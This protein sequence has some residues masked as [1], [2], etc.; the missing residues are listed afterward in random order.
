MSDALS[1]DGKVAI[2]T[3]AAGGIGSE[4]AR[5]LGERGANVVLG[6]LPGTKLADAAATVQGGK[7]ATF[8]VDISSE[9]NVEAL[10]AFTIETFGRLD[11]VD[12]NAARQGLPGDTNIMSMTVEVWDSV[13]AVNA[14]G[15]MLMA[16]HSLPHMIEQGGGSIINISSGTAQAGD[17]FASA[18]ACTKGAIN[19]LTRYVATQYGAQ[20]VRCN[21]IAPGLVATPALEAGMP[22]VMKDAMVRAGKLVPRLGQPRDI[23]EVVAFLASDASSWITGQVFPVD[24]GFFAHV[25]T[26]DAVRQLMAGMAEGG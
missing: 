25:P 1:L 15:D 7:A 22:D 17:M 2:V 24:G 9:A 20:G 10:M 13:F 8:E 12:N 6:D 16:K 21:A 14:R 26:L 5:L 23:A 11:I 18:Y 4:T 3:G 19:T